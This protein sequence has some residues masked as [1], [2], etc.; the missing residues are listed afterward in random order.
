MQII[1]EL[2][3]VR[4]GS[5]CGSIGLFSDWGHVCLNIAIRTMLLSGGREVGRFDRLRGTLDYAA[6]GGIVADSDPGQ[7]YRESLDKTAVARAVLEMNR[8]PCTASA[9]T[10]RSWF[11]PQA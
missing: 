7:E 3:P 5:Y 9:T 10:G 8:T 11:R 6:G 4:R 2:E 1:D